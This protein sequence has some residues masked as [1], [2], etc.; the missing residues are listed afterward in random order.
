MVPLCSIWAASLRL[1]GTQN[2][3]VICPRSKFSTWSKLLEDLNL[4]EFDM[5]GV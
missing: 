5:G 4:I 1:L 3:H 2:D